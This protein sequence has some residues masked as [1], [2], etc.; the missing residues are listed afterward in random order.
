MPCL[1]DKKIC[2]CVK[3]LLFVA[4]WAVPAK[5]SLAEWYI[6]RSMVS[7]R[8]D[9]QGH[10]ILKV[11]SGQHTSPPRFAFTMALFTYHSTN[12]AAPHPTEVQG[13]SFVGSTGGEDG[14][15]VQLLSFVCSTGGKGS[16]L[17]LWNIQNLGPV[18][19]YRATSRGGHSTMQMNDF[20]TPTFNTG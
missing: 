15:E 7:E 2:Q 17:R 5:V 16:K 6:S 3:I 10:G 18:P 11:C 8:V 19:L 9:R 14:T 20:F 1:R 12:R 13:L 4:M